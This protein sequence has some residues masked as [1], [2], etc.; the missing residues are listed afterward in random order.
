MVNGHTHLVYKLIVFNI[1]NFT[2]SNIQS[3]RKSI[4]RFNLQFFVISIS[5]QVPVAVEFM[6]ELPL[7]AIGKV[8]RKRL[9][10]METEKK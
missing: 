4:S 6:T 7:T 5:L 10:Q 8:D 2:A 1:T 3:I 9:R